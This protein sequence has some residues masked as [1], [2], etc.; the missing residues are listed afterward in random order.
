MYLKV[1]PEWANFLR[2][3]RG[4]H[5]PDEANSLP[6]NGKDKEKNGLKTIKLDGTWKL[7][8]STGQRGGA[9]YVY[10][11]IDHRESDA[12]FKGEPRHLAGTYQGGWLDA[13]VPGEVHLDLMNAG[14]LDDPRDGINVFKA[15]WVEE[16]IWY[17]RR[18]FDVP[19]EALT[20]NVYLHFE[21]LDLWITMAGGNGQE[22]SIH[23]M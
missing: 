19:S 10:K 20:G 6:F 7:H 18:T 5:L 22:T 12:A 1:R 21:E 2:K 23:G 15:R 3:G 17:Y 8:W 14:L 16:M 4:R 11:H 9:P 13:T